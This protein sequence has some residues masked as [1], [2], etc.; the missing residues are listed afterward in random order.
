[1]QEY[2]G[3]DSCRCGTFHHALC[4]FMEGL[5]AKTGQPI[6]LR[7]GDHPLIQ[8]SQNMGKESRPNT[9][10]LVLVK[11]PSSGIA[12]S[13]LAGADVLAIKVEKFSPTD[14]TEIQQSSGNHD[15]AHL[16]T[17]GQSSQWT[18]SLPGVGPDLH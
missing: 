16:E 13:V 15:R 6:R 11:I 9:E 2:T 17:P 1:H 10:I 5:S 12:V 3:A 4:V 7:V 8:G 14:Q 18:S